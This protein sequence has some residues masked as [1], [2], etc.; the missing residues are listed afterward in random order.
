MTN[1]EPKKKKKRTKEH[2]LT[3]I[4][5]DVQN[6]PGKKTKTDLLIY[7]IVSLAENVCHVNFSPWTPL[8]FGEKSKENYQNLRNL[9][10]TL[11][12]RL[13][14]SKVLQ[15]FDQKNLW[16]T[17]LHCNHLSWV[18]DTIYDERFVLRLLA[19]V[20]GHGS[21]LPLRE[22]TEM[23]ALSLAFSCTSSRNETTR[24]AAYYVLQRY[25]SLLNTLTI[26]TFDQRPILV[27]LLRLFKNSVETEAQLVSNVISQYFARAAK[28]SLN[29]ESVVY[30]AV[31][32]FLT[33]NCFHKMPFDSIP[34]LASMLFSSSTQHH[35]EERLF[36]LDVVRYGCCEPNDYA[37][38]TSR[39]GFRSIIS[40][41]SSPLTNNNA[42]L[43]I[44]D[45]LKRLS[46]MPTPS[47]DLIHRLNLPSWLAL[48]MG[49]KEVTHFERG[50]LGEI[51]SILISTE[52]QRIRDGEASLPKGQL[53]A[54]RIAA[55]E[56]VERLR[57]LTNDKDK[58]IADEIEKLMTKKWR[59][60][61]KST[62]VNE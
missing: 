7:E 35:K 12:I 21:E 55:K 40:L 29:A 52:Y 51:F 5:N 19:S 26:E 4:I 58:R 33:K 34:D 27:F 14:P 60:S 53:A 3:Q 39:G 24:K 9:G 32:S 37:L 10:S 8:V 57:E 36:L 17:V 22:F 16:T 13:E 31:M 41:F 50:Y 30:P 47:H 59:G 61:R 48:Q 25:L 38:I 20:M 54:I 43:S 18:S 42:R 44:L 6:A 45:L 23:G 62:Q 56:A 15:Y 28:L 49:K 1:D 11:H 46:T 2:D